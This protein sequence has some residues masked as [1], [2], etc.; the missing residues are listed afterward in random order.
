LGGVLGLVLPFSIFSQ[1][2]KNDRGAA[3]PAGE[4]KAL[5]VSACLQCHGAKEIASQRMD[6]AGW[7][8]NV[9]DMVS[10]G[11]QLFPD[12]ID[13]VVN[14]LAKNFGPKESKQPRK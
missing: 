8:R 10:K 4:G 2:V 6:A 9:H 1:Q 14:Y 11:A 5:V 12:E 13:G 7:G 3:L